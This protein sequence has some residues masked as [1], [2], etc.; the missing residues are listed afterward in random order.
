M[1]SIDNKETFIGGVVFFFDEDAF[2][3]DAFDEDAFDDDDDDE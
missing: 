3:E 2:D 1:S